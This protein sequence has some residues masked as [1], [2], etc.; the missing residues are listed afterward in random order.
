MTAPEETRRPGEPRRETTM[1]RKYQG[2]T[3]NFFEL[4][5]Q[6]AVRVSTFPTGEPFNAI[7]DFAGGAD[8]RMYASLCGEGFESLSAQLYEFT[9]GRPELEFLFDLK[10]EV[11]VSP[12]AIPPSKIHT[13]I[14]PTRDG[15]LIM[16]THMTARAPRHPGWLPDHYF[17][18]QHEGFPGSDVLLLDPDSKDLRVLGRAVAR[19][20]VYGAAYDGRHNA[21]YMSTFLRGRLL[22]LDLDTREVS[23][24]GQLGEYGSYCLPVDRRGNFY[25]SS[26]SGHLFHIDVDTQRIR[27][28]A[29]IGAEPEPDNPLW[30]GGIGGPGGG[31]RYLAHWTNGPDGRLYFVAHFSDLLY[32]VDPVT[33]KM[34]TYPLGLD[35]PR[36]REIPQVLMGITFDARGVLWYL[37]ARMCVDWPGGY[38]VHLRRA[39]ILRGGRPETAGLVGT[40]ERALVAASETILDKNGIWHLAD[41][42]HSLDLPRIVSLDLNRLAGHSPTGRG[43]VS[44]D[45]L[46]YWIDTPYRAHFPGDFDQAIKPHA[47]FKQGYEKLGAWTAE[48]ART[49]IRAGQAWGFRVWEHVPWGEDP[50]VR[51]M[52]F[53]GEDDLLVWAGADGRHRFRLRDGALVEHDPAAGDCPAPAAL[54]AAAREAEGLMPFRQG[55]Q[56]KRRITACAPWNGG[57]LVAGTEDGLLARLGPAAGAVFALGGIGCHGPVHQLAANADG[58]RL[59]GVSG[60]PDDL[61]SVFVY[62]DGR[63]LRE[64]GRTFLELPGQMAF[65]NTQPT[66]VACSPSGEG[67]AVGT[68]GRMGTV[69]GFRH[70]EVTAAGPIRTLDLP[71]VRWQA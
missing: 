53:E 57:R 43:P 61:G 28:F 21:Y 36:R 22:R 40:P 49:Q 47:E 55:R 3:D 70:P 31:R 23:D 35:D 16:A 10:R 58:T 54:P 68:A 24:L 30:G 62:D 71:Q 12:R 7:W 8:G 20:S 34:E 69:Y 52:V 59:Y 45:P 15:K 14:R 38:L 44:E 4:L 48:E 11:M 51:A 60:D 26:R 18:H 64:L 1:T 37:S 42:N 17:S 63:G 6:E 50:G 27:D 29:R 32:A 67:F 65:C 56:Y 33:L 13:C 19:D 46:P 66:T 9:Y 2:L 41:T 25:M 5:P 39:D